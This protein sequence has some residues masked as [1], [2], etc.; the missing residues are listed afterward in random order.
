MKI[1]IVVN[2]AWAAYNFRFNL[3]QAL[4]K[5]GYKVIFVIPFDG[6][7]S[8]KLQKKFQCKDLYLN[9]RGLSP[10]QDFK[11]FLNLVR[12]FKRISP[13]VVCNFTIKPNIYGSIA[14][15]V[16]NIPCIDNITGLGTVF[17]ERS[18]STLI[19]KCLYRTSLSKY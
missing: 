19:V 14:A 5:A 15:K 11:T 6:K 17:I 12:I 3:A 2:S 9:A 1:V 10:F 18:L 8:D 4:E 7:Y 16:Y 13:D